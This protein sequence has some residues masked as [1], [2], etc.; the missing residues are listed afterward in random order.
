MREGRVAEVLR[1]RLERLVLLCRSLREIRG[2]TNLGT[3]ILENLLEIIDS[4]LA[5][6]V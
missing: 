2:S 5:A 6:G 3:G 1:R 4:L